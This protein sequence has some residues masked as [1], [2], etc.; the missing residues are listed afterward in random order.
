MPQ[1]PSKRSSELKEFAA[2]MAHGESNTSVSLRGHRAYWCSDFAVQSSVSPFSGSPWV[3]TV[4]MHSN[5]TFGAACVNGQGAMNEHTASGLV[6]LYYTGE[7][8]DG[9]FDV[10]DWTRLPGITTEQI[11]VQSCNYSNQLA[12]DSSRMALTGRPSYC[13]SVPCSELLP[14]RNSDRRTTRVECNVTGCTQFDS[15]EGSSNAS[16]R[17]RPHGR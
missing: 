16:A 2:A 7:E 13:L 8:Y 10:W 9:I 6:Y 4:L 15:K 1:I 11:P 14:C 17:H 5:R 3:A 12:R